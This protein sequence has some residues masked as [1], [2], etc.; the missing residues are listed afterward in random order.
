MDMVARHE[1]VQFTDVRSWS[2]QA[3]VYFVVVYFVGDIILN[4]R[5]WGHMG[6]DE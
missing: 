6:H 2:R 3:D 5:V 1:D 4:V